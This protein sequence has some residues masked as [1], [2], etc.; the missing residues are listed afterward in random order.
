[1]NRT[2]ALAAN[3]QRLAKLVRNPAVQ[4]IDA[5]DPRVLAAAVAAG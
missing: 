4:V 5:H 2:S 3:H 1:M